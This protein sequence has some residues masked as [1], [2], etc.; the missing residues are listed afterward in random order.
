M[1]IAMGKVRQRNWLLIITI[2]LLLSSVVVLFVT[3]R[4]RLG[5]GVCIYQDVEYL[6]GQLVPNY[7]EGSECYCTWTGEIICEDEGPLVSYEDFSSEG[8]EFTYSFRN[9]LEKED[10]DYT[11]SVLSGLKHR[12]GV[13]EVIVERESL[14]GEAGLAPVQTA[15]YKKEEESLTLT[16]ITNRD[17]TL[18]TRVCMVG[19]TFTIE[20]VDLTEDTEYSLYYQNDNGQV[21]TLRTCLANGRL[22]GEGDVF[23]DSNGDLLCTCV[24]PEIECEE[25]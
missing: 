2:F 15:M 20:D 16:T 14:C 25:L 9:F 13:L 10:P 22:Y 12:E 19:N 7:G 11:R 21:S 1:G 18:Y 8:L 5:V 3:T 6:Q 24:S 4:S 23:K 17:P